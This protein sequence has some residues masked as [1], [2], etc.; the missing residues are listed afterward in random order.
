MAYKPTILD[1][2]NSNDKGVAGNIPFKN[3]V[4]NL[5]YLLCSICKSVENALFTAALL[6]WNAIPSSVTE[7]WNATAEWAS[8]MLL[9]KHQVY[10]IDNYY[11]LCLSL[12]HHR[13]LQL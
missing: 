13:S 12:R 3:V 9:N 1:V 10:I 8:A 6:K 11:Y 2:T 7:N 4:F 5:L